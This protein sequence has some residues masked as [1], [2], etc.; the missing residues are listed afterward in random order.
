MFLEVSQNSQENNCTR[1]SFLCYFIKK[2]TLAQVRSCEFCDISKNTYFT[3]HPRGTASAWI[4]PDKIEFFCEKL[5]EN[6]GPA[7]HR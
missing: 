6:C 3:E 1:I 4:D 7:L 5:F 2:E